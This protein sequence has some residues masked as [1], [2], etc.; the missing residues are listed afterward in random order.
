MDTT[1]ASDSDSGSY[2]DDLWLYG[3]GSLLWK[4]PLHDIPE[5]SS[6]FV[7]HPGRVHGFIRR[8][9]QSSC[10]NRGTPEFKGRVVTIV[11]Y[12]EVIAMEQKGYDTMVREYELKEYSAEQQNVLLSGGVVDGVGSLQDA[13]VVEGVCYSIGARNGHAAL[14]RKYL[15]FREKDGYSVH[16]VD[17]VPHGTSASTTTCEVYVGTCENASFIGAESVAATAAVIRA[18]TGESGPNDE[19][20]LLLHRACPSDRYLGALAAAL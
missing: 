7:R 10:D 19:Y 4:P 2:S 16:R 6:E 15:D 17:F 8:F 3:Y 18:A 14:A 1:E 5:I 9:W 13:L 11:P 12:N 20:L